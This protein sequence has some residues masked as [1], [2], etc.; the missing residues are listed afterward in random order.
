VAQVLR[1]GRDVL[2]V[3]CGP[4]PVLA[5][6][7]AADLLAA[8]GVSATVLNMHTVKPLDVER[9]CA[10]AAGVPLVVA[11]EE[12]WRTGGLGGAVAETLA[13]HA[14]VRVLRVGVADTFVGV[15]GDHDALTEHYGIAPV[16]IV[17]QVRTALGLAA[18]PPAIRSTKEVRSTW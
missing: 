5:C 15:V 17:A 2:L 9:L 18:S 1:A 10:G 4:H 11:V 13:E 3:C 8:D 16:A 7:A 12:H 6:L 14:P